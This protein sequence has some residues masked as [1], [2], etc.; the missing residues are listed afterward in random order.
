MLFLCFKLMSLFTSNLLIS[1]LTKYKVELRGGIHHEIGRFERTTGS[2]SSCGQHHKLK[3]KDRSFT[4]TRCGLVSDR[5]CSSAIAVERI[6][7]L[8]LMANGSVVRVSKSPNTQQK[9]GVKTKVFALA[10]LSLGSE[11]IDKAA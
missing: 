6:G 1:D 9:S 7:E 5:D 3:L 11:E 8:D 10:K 2:C 4:C